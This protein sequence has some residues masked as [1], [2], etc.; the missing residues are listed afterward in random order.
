MLK[1]FADWVEDMAQ[2]MVTSVTCQ[3]A[4]RNPLDVCIEAEEAYIRTTGCN[5]NHFVVPTP[6]EM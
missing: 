1:P 2:Q 3:N 6:K 5:F 4:L